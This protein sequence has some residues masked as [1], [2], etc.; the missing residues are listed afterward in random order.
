MKTLCAAVS[1]I[2]LAA[3]TRQPINAAGIYRLSTAE[4][5]MVLEVRTGGEY[6]L[7]INGAERNP[8]QLRGRWEDGREPGVDVA[9]HGLQWRGTEPEAGQGI[10]AA[11]FESNGGI[12]LNAEGL[13][14]FIKDDPA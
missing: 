12:C 2:V 13:S 3:C 4:K 7:Q 8:D 9:F 1:L 10:W 6:V 14:C 11:T 5:S